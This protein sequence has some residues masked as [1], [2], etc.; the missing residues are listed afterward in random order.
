LS[1]WAFLLEIEMEIQMEKCY[2]CK[3]RTKEVH[4]LGH[5]Q[6]LQCLAY[7][8]GIIAEL[9]AREAEII[10]ERL[11]EELN[12]VAVRVGKPPYGED[13]TASF[14][15]LGLRFVQR[16]DQHLI[17]RAMYAKRGFGSEYTP[18]VEINLEGQKFQVYRHGPDLP[19]FYYIN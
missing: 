5:P 18:H 10:D 14:K 16:L 19:D 1:D 2:W 11:L 8:A 13:L 9:D 12:K 3:A 6:C 17:E 15:Y 4:K 7:E